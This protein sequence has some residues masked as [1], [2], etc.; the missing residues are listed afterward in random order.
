MTANM[1]SIKEYCLRCDVEESFVQQLA[2]TGL[3]ELLEEQQTS[4]IPEEQIEGLEKFS[5]FYYDMDINIEGIEVISHLL[6]K[7]QAMHT[8]MNRMKT[9]LRLHDN[10]F[11][12]SF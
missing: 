7:M 3:I 5:R 10:D 12:I 11:N 6:E 1:I 8:E 2:S 9:L 4:F